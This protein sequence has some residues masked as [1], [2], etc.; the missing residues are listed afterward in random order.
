[1]RSYGMI[2]STSALDGGM[3]QTFVSSDSWRENFI[4]D[5]DLAIC[6]ESELYCSLNVVNVVSEVGE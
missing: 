6:Y 3:L 2:S 5:D 4:F 1:M